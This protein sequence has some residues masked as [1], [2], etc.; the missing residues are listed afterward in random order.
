LRSPCFA[1]APGRAA[2][3][4]GGLWTICSTEADV[5]RSSRRRPRTM[6]RRLEAGT[7]L[8]P[9]LETARINF[10]YTDGF[11]EAA[12]KRT[13]NVTGAKANDPAQITKRYLTHRRYR[14][15]RCRQG[16]LATCEG[17]CPT[18]TRSRPRHR[19]FPLNPDRR[20]LKQHAPLSARRSI[21]STTWNSAV[22]IRPS[23]ISQR[24]THGLSN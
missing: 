13:A 16:R 21:A 14:G 8:Q 6:G 19:A 10:D 3:G 11:S 12:S 23:R 22:P 4:P 18:F 5:A 2:D 15:H 24:H 20:V 1:Q 7:S 17:H 9:Q